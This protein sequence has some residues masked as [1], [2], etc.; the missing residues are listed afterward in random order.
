VII[1]GVRLPV[2]SFEIEILDSRESVDERKI[3]IPNFTNRFAHDRV[4]PPLPDSLSTVL[5]QSIQFVKLT[6]EKDIKLRIE[7]IEAFQIFHN[8]DGSEVEH[9]KVEQVVTAI[10]IETNREIDQIAVN[11]WG[12]KDGVDASVHHIE[13][14]YKEAFVQH[15]L[16][17]VRNLNFES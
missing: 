8:A 3:A 4:N 2:K 9:V 6:G 10:D 14:M 15:F 12:K 16:K 11:C 1:S 5:K 13:Q 17:A 7:I